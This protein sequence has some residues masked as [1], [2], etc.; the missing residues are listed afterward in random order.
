MKRITKKALEQGGLI[1]PIIA[2]KDLNTGCMNPGLCLHE[3]KLYVNLRHVE[4][5]LHHSEHKQHFNSLWG[6]LSYLH[7][8]QDPR[9][10]TNNYFGEYKNGEFILGK[11]DTSKLDVP[12][13]W[14]FVGLEDA[15]VVVW[16]EKIYLCGVRRDTTTN[17]QGRMEMSEIVYNNGWKEINRHRIETPLHYDSYCEKNWMPVKDRPYQFVK[18]SNPTEVVMAK[19]DKVLPNGN[20][21]SRQVRYKKSPVSLPRDI[22]GGSNVIPYDGG[23]IAITHETDFWYNYK[24]NKDAQYYHRILRWDNDFTLTHISEEF[25]FLGGYIEFCTGL[26][27]LPNGNFAITFGFQ[28][29]VAYYLEVPEK[30]ITNELKAI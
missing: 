28:D 6:P 8:E 11:V 17:G 26:E 9:L 14:T 20:V 23:Y 12:P 1:R 27:Y 22:R 30:V 18:W 2:N 5:I 21:K 29:N 15:R 3:D 24:G 13:I 19:L 7:P 16:D 25:K 10:V 4:Y